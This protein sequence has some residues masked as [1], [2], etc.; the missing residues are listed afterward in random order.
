MEIFSRDFNLEAQLS[1]QALGKFLQTEIG[2]R[3][4]ATE[5]QHR[6]AFVLRIKRSMILE[7]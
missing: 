6:L 7:K 1:G 4:G 2:E 3:G 5:Y